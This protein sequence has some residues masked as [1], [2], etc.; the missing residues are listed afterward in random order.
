MATSSNTLKRTENLLFQFD[1]N[2]LFIERIFLIV[3]VLRSFIR[4]YVRLAVTSSLMDGTYISARI[5]S[6]VH[7]PMIDFRYG[8]FPC[9]YRLS[10]LNDCRQLELIQLSITSI[11]V[12]YGTSRLNYAIKHSTKTPL[13]QKH[14]SW[15]YSIGKLIILTSD[16]NSNDRTSIENNNVNSSSWSLNLSP[17][18]HN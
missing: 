3:F 17:P 7:V 8:N 11:R 1:S 12:A 14:L 18:S 2:F 5:A 4:A 6:L 10:Q 16:N 13:R 9:F 15:Q